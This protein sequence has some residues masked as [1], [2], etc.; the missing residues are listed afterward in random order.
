MS[1]KEKTNIKGALMTAEQISTEI[2]GGGIVPRVIS[3][4]HSLQK[5]FPKVRQFGFNG[6]KFWARD[7]IYNFYDVKPMDKAA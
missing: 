2:F 6:K 5:G 1:K 7:E 3:E 4:K